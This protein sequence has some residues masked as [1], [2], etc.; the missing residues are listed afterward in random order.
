MNLGQNGIE[1]LANRTWRDLRATARMH[2]FH[3]DNRWTHA[4]A[5]AA[6]RHFL[7]GQNQLGKIIRRLSDDERAA[8]MALKAHDGRIRRY[9]FTQHFGQ[10]RR[11][12]PSHPASPWKVAGDHTGGVLPRAVS[13]ASHHVPATVSTTARL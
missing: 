4:D 10:I 2:N 8:L 9:T 5:L 3:F 6:L 13:S 7:L 12:R 11:Y 1:L